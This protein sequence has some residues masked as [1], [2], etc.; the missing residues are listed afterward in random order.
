MKKQLLAGMLFL[1][2]SSCANAQSVHVDGEQ[3]FLIRKSICE[4]DPIALRHL[5]EQ[6]QFDSVA[7]ERYVNIGQ[8]RINCVRQNLAQMVPSRSTKDNMRLALGILPAVAACF[9]ILR[10]NDICYYLIQ[11]PEDFQED[12]IKLARAVTVLGACCYTSVDLIKKGLVKHYSQHNALTRALAVQKELEN[13]K[14][15]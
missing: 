14:L 8:E 9:V 2:Y 5:L 3:D 13:I 12:C 15:N 4:S 6:T 7:K 1:V 11:N 10:I